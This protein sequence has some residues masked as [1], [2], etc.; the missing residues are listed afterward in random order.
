MSYAIDRT[1]SLNT[2][3][4][5]TT[6]VSGLSLRWFC[7][8]LLVL[9]IV[10]TFHSRPSAAQSVQ[11]PTLQVCSQTKI[12]ANAF[13]RI[14]SRIDAAHSGMFVL[15]G[16]LSC[17]PKGSPYP[18]GSLGIS[19]LSMSDSTVQGDIVFTTYEQVTTTGKHSPMAWVNGRCKTQNA[20]GVVIEGCHYWLMMANNNN[21]FQNGKTPDIVSILVFDATGKRVA[22]GTGP[23]VDGDVTIAGTSN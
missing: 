3:T 11:I 12:S 1:L 6:S 5:R 21:Q 23:T 20:A 8:A 2:A 14:E 22:Y 4:A 18:T 9:F 16:D 19:G 10:T 15:R 13:V 7:S 17:D